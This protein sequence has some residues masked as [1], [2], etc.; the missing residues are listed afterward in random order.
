MST[1]SRV[2]ALQLQLL[3]ARLDSFVSISRTKSGSSVIDGRVITGGPNGNYRLEL[4]PRGS[5]SFARVTD[6]GILTPIRDVESVPFRGLVYNLKTTDN[7]YLVSNAVVHNCGEEACPGCP[8]V[9]TCDR[10]KVSPLCLCE[11][12]A[13][14]KGVYELYQKTFEDRAGPAS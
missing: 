12:H 6:F 1:T 4:R 13:P 14:E 8:Y 11:K 9:E 10:R 7:T 3:A 2:L 5:Q